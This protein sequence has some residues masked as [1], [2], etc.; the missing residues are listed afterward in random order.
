MSEKMLERIFPVLAGEPADINGAGLTGDYI[1]LKNWG[2]VLVVLAMG[3]GT[4][5]NDVDLLC[6]QATDVSGSDAK[7]LNALETG[8]IYRIQGADYAAYAALTGSTFV[9]SKVTQ[10]TADEQYTPTD[11]GEA[12]GIICLE[13][14]REDLDTTNNFDCIR[15]D[16]SDPS[17]SKIC[18]LL[19]ILGDPDYPMAPELQKAPI[20]D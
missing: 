16:L 5:S 18:T 7:V 15:V 1:S 8:R 14:R 3:D 11:N 20:V 2:R 9:W 4:A 13:L 12:V 19:Y 10:A 17:A 6:Y